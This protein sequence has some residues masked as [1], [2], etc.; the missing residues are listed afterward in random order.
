M[1]SDKALLGIGFVRLAPDRAHAWPVEAI[2]E[3]AVRSALVRVGAILRV[4]VERLATPDDEVEAR[5]LGAA[6]D[7]HRPLVDALCPRV[8][9]KAPDSELKSD[10]SK[11]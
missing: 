3:Q 4:P 8:V 2:V 6:V 5:L 7:H 1:E 11:D 9:L 10:D